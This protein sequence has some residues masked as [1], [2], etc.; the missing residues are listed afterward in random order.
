MFTACPLSSLL[1]QLVFLLH[2]Y[3]LFFTL[4]ALLAPGEGG[5]E[6]RIEGA[7]RECQS[8]RARE[9]DIERENERG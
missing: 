1:L 9:T 7:G 2:P 8:E 3:P 6:G 5:R 4:L